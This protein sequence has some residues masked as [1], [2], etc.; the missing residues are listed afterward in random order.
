[1]AVNPV[2]AAE[3]AAER[4]QAAMERAEEARDVALAQVET[5]NE[6][7]AVELEKINLV[8]DT[9]NDTVRTY[10]GTVTTVD[11]VETG[12]DPAD[13][14][15]IQ[16]KHFATQAQ[17]DAL[18]AAQGLIPGARYLVRDNAGK[19][20]K[21]IDVDENGLAYILKMPETVD[22]LAGLN[23]I[24]KIDLLPFRANALPAGWYFANGD[25]YRLDSPQ[26]QKLNGLSAAY[27]SDWAITLAGTA[28]NQTINLP[29]MFHSDGRGFFR[30]PG[31]SP[32]GIE[33]DA[34]QNIWGGIS[35]NVDYPGNGSDWG[36]MWRQDYGQAKQTTSNGAPWYYTTWY[37]DASRVART[38][39]ETRPLYRNFTPAIFLGV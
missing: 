12:T 39:G 8:V 16:L 22:L 27:K 15:N 29:K 37:F 17:Y 7:T 18:A 38:A 13:A 25:R 30:R 26:G 11:G 9:L 23:I 24:G 5:I 31:S 32:G 4:A 36:A 2:N 3:M 20:I 1:M 35:S 28:P 14:R 10:G 33:D 21:Q 19:I 6:L 34:I